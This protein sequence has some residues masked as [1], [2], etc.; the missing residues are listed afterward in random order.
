MWRFDHSCF[1]WIFCASAIVVRWKLFRIEIRFENLRNF[2]C[3]SLHIVN[4]FLCK[5]KTLHI[6]SNIYSLLT[7]IVVCVGRASSRT[8]Q[9]RRKTL[10]IDRRPNRSIDQIS[11]AHIA[12]YRRTSD[13]HRKRVCDW[14]SERHRAHRLLPSLPARCGRR[15]ATQRRRCVSLWF[16]F[17]LFCCYWS[18]I[19]R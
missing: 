5:L 17:H 15:V 2:A 11:R 19:W 18:R 13:V 6:Y 3:Y 4:I 9:H 14:R 7:K 12:S 1:Y 8:T 16:H 10:D